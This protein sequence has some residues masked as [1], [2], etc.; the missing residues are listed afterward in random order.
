MLFLYI[1]IPSDTINLRQPYHPDKIHC[2][3]L[4]DRLDYLKLLPQDKR[5]LVKNQLPHDNHMVDNV[6]LL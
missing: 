5:Q 1:D 2:L 4:A 6:V 3:N